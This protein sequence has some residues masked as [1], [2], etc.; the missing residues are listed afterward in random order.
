VS[1]RRTWAPSFHSVVGKAWRTRRRTTRLRETRETKPSSATA[2]LFRS[3]QSSVS[4]YASLEQRAR[5]ERDGERRNWEKEE[6]NVLCRVAFLVS[7]VQSRLSAASIN[8]KE[9]PPVF[10]PYRKLSLSS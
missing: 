3:T 5:N 8:G 6:W 2:F 1:G 10:N 4:F 7:L 9:R